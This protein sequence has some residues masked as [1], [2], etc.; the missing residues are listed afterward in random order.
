MLCVVSMCVYVC[1]QMV[2]GSKDRSSSDKDSE[3]K[4]PF[5]LGYA[6]NTLYVLDN[7]SARVQMF[8]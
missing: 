8:T 5:S 6:K 2:L 3:F 7:T 1:M 4:S